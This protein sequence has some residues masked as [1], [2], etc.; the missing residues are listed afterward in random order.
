[1]CS[2]DL[3]EVVEVRAV[4]V[5]T[6]ET[7]DRTVRRV[8]RAGRGVARPRVLAE[9]TKEALLV[10]VCAAHLTLTMSPVPLLWNACSC[11]LLT[12]SGSTIHA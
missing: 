3:A 12:H 7:Q 8:D 4:E 1:M 6:D 9:T 2:S 5:S 11:T 10:R